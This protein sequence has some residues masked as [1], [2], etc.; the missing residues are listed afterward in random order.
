MTDHGRATRAT[1]AYVTVYD[2]TV[3]KLETPEFTAM[4]GWAEF[5]DAITATTQVFVAWHLDGRHRRRPWFFPESTVPRVHYAWVIVAIAL[6]WC[7]SWAGALLLRHA[8]AGDCRSLGLTTASKVFSVP[9]ISPT[10]WRVFSSCRGGAALGSAIAAVV[11]WRSPPGHVRDV[12][13]LRLS[14]GGEQLFC[15]RSRS[16]AAFVGAMSLPSTVSPLAPGARRRRGGG[17]RRGRDFIL[18]L[19]VPRAM[20]V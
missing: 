17:R 16:A 5:A 6:W 2:L 9:P 19:L 3:W 10:V 4:R 8:A 7:S 12:S 11:A 15:R 14:G 18:G 13:R 1:R 20:M